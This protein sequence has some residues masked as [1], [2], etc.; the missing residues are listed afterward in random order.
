MNREEI[1]SEVLCELVEAYNDYSSKVQ[2]CTF[3]E[4]A[5]ERIIKAINEFKK[6]QNHLI[7]IQSNF[8]LN[9]NCVNDSQAESFFYH[10]ANSF[11]N[12]I[13]FK[14]FLQS[15]EEKNFLI[16]RDYID[17]LCDTDIISKYNFH[18]NDFFEKKKYIRQK[19][20]EYI[21]AY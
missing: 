16:C 3:E 18:E 21:D 10:P 19:L 15:L 8:S 2:T 4:Y 13:I 20:M 17:G 1:E 5:K 7:T 6:Y 12:S 9:Q 14:M 11:E